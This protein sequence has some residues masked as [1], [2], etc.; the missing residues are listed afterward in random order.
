MCWRMVSRSSMNST[1]LLCTRRSVTWWEMRTI[2]S[3]LN[4]IVW[5][6]SVPFPSGALKRGG[7]ESTQ[8][9]FLIASELAFHFL[10]HFLIGDAGAAHL[11]LVLDENVAHLIVDA[12]LNGNFLH[13]AGADADRDGIDFLFLDF[14]K[15][16]SEEFFDDFGGHVADIIAVQEHLKGVLGVFLFDY[17]FTGCEGKPQEI[18]E[19]K[20]GARKVCPSGEVPV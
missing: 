18:R 12:V 14:D 17:E 15:A 6:A 3:R 1:S 10:E 4:L 20:T 8:N 7:G 11:I 9:Q 16:V 13:H 19:K 5:C 2:F